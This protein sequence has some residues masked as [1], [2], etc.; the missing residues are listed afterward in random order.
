[1][2]KLTINFSLKSV[3]T[4]LRPIRAVISFGY[5]EHD[6]M[7]QKNV[8]KPVFTNT[9]LKA[10]VEEWSNLDKNEKLKLQLDSIEKKITTIYEG[11]CETEEFS[12]DKFIDRL[13]FVILG[14]K[15]QDRVVKRIRLVDYIE[16]HILDAG[17]ES[18]V[19]KQPIQETDDSKQ[20][21]PPLKDGTFE[22]YNTLR[23]Q[24]LKVE[25]ELGKPIYS[26]EF[27]ESH[28]DVF[29]AHVRAN[30]NRINSVYFLFKNLRAVLNKIAAQF[31][32]P[33]FNPTMAVPPSK[34]VRAV[35]TRKAIV[36]YDGI[37]QVLAFDPPE[38]YKNTKLIF[39]TLYFSGVR[40]SDVFKVKPEKLYEGN[41]VSFSY[42]ELV[43]KKGEKEVIIPILKPL[44]E[45]FTANGGKPAKKVH[46]TQFNADIKVLLAMCGFNEDLTLPYIDSYGKKQFETK[47][48]CEFISSHTG[49]R[50]FISTLRTKIPTIIL[51]K[52]TGHEFQEDSESVIS[53]YD[54]LSLMDYVIE[55]AHELKRIQRTQKDY[56][57]FQLI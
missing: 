37:R 50:S 23:K 32:V 44:E 2:E 5:K 52:I 3:T 22:G 28:F 45:A 16:Q 30:N 12:R 41:G 56:F 33:V 19:K 39:L 48:H 1:M 49:R 34:R 43:T 25:A 18:R 24:L 35:K 38:R 53:D 36:K 20:K 51:S 14:K 21:K 40:Y 55:F 47:K 10:T 42:C 8:Y 29:M 6:V 7:S 11:L 9:G 57:G 31:K 15:P 46:E 26:H 27:D 54:Q 17:K 13:N 4:N